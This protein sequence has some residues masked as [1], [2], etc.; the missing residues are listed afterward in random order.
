[1]SRFQELKDLFKRRL[2]NE[3]RADLFE[4]FEESISGVEKEIDHKRKLLDLVLHP[5]VKL[6]RAES[7]ADVQQLLENKE[8]LPSSSRDHQD[9]DSSHIKEEQE[10]VWTSQEGEQL[11]E[12][13]EVDITKFIL[14]PVPVKSEDDE[15]KPQS[16]QLHQT[17]TEEIKT[18][19]DGE[20]CGGSEPDR[21][22]HPDT[23]LQPD[24]DD[25][26]SDSS[27]RVTGEKQ[28]IYSD[29]G[30]SSYT[31]S[32]ILRHHKSIPLKTVK[33]ARNH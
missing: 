31:T 17:L 24:T 13:E 22:S 1:M 18:E 29:Q 26:I 6:L 27:E 19:A 33:K 16:S 7:P 15:E 25:K 12:L 21:N 23:H 8:E 28:F 10:E 2:I 30:Y 11:Q 9:P 32:V 14:T 3:A 4:H 20:D 5:D